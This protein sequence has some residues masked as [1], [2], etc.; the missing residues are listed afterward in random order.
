M[1]KVWSVCAS[2]CESVDERRVVSQKLKLV[3]VFVVCLGRGGEVTDKVRRVLIPF[4]ITSN[5]TRFSACACTTAADCTCRLCSPWHFLSLTLVLSATQNGYWFE[6][7][8]N[9]SGKFSWGSE[10]ANLD[11]K[12]EGQKLTSL[13]TNLQWTVADKMVHDVSPC[14]IPEKPD[15]SRKGVMVLHYLAAMP[16]TEDMSLKD[17]MLQMVVLLTFL[18]GQR[19]QSLHSL[20]V[21]DVRMF[22]QKCVTNSSKKQKRTRWGYSI[23]QSLLLY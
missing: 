7:T 17:L 11:A 22:S 15:T 14:T 16:D 8:W 6:C 3:F 18:H 21:S 5:S 23:T 20:K 9:F 2:G 4:S 13:I 12:W 19:G 10:F 1:H